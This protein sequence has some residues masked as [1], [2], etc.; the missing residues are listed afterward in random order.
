MTKILLIVCIC[1][2]LTLLFYC[3]VP[4]LSDKKFRMLQVKLSVF[5]RFISFSVSSHSSF[6][7]FIFIFVAIINF[8]H[9]NTFQLQKQNKEKIAHF[10][11]IFHLD[12]RNLFR[13][14]HKIE[15]R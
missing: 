3:Q 7:D 6:P 5:E 8:N 12:K 9:E 14:H 2:T 10:L 13:K 1:Q 11:N 15:R 4:Y